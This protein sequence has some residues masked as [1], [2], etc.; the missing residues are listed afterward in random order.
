MIIFGKSFL[1]KGFSK[2]FPKTFQDIY[3]NHKV[4]EGCGESLKI[5]HSPETEFFSY[6]DRYWYYQLCF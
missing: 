1:K 5:K 4:F 3:I 6:P 2:P